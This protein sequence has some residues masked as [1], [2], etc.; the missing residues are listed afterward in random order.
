[1]VLPPPI[2]PDEGAGYPPEQVLDG[3]IVAPSDHWIALFP[4]RR[5]DRRQPPG[6]DGPGRA[7]PPPSRHAEMEA[8]WA[9]ART[10][11][12]EVTR[13]CGNALIKRMF[14]T[15]ADGWRY[16]L[17][18]D[19][20]DARKL[21][22]SPVPTSSIGPALHVLVL[23]TTPTP[24]AHYNSWSFDIEMI[25]RHCGGVFG[26][27]MHLRDFLAAFAW[28]DRS[29]EHAMETT[30]FW[31]WDLEQRLAADRRI[32]EMAR[33]WRQM[34][35][36][37]RAKGFL[38]R[39]KIY[40]AA[41]AFDHW[42]P[43]ARRHAF[44]KYIKEEGRRKRAADLCRWVFRAF[45]MS[46]EA[47]AM[48]RADREQDARLR[49]PVR[50]FLRC[51]PFI[52]TPDQA[53][54][55]GVSAPAKV[56]TIGPPEGLRDIGFVH[57]DPQSA[58]L[59]QFVKMHPLKKPHHG[60]ALLAPQHTQP[61]EIRQKWRAGDGTM[62]VLRMGDGLTDA[63]AAQGLGG[64]GLIKLPSDRDAMLEVEPS[65]VRFEDFLELGVGMTRTVT[66]TNV[67][68]TIRRVRVLPAQSPF[69]TVTCTT[70]RNRGRLAP[71][72]SATIKVVF[73]PQE[74]RSYY[75]CVVIEAECDRTLNVRA[76]L[77]LPLHGTPGPELTSPDIPD[78]GRGALLARNIRPLQRMFRVEQLAL[79]H[80]EQMRQHLAK[81]MSEE[82]EGVPRTEE[83]KEVAAALAELEREIF[84]GGG[85]VPA[86]V[87]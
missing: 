60:G 82:A 13:H 34:V 87:S 49:A 69:F 33:R 47:S 32:K 50:E 85:E 53:F 23:R 9:Y 39:W 62:R 10:K 63:Q 27:Q 24:A 83:L 65:V 36:M 66:M 20:A 19:A 72:M 15:L 52:K 56:Y 1:M 38:R 46:L 57:T 26:G 16:F 45:R 70:T 44:A 71:G 28:D 30:Y 21:C 3:A 7:A 58:S 37:Q 43:W 35:K 11:Q 5:E 67:G 74:K 6:V 48:E 75:D 22:S 25:V 31:L 59:T 54:L 42:G 79:S 80:A 29:F 14:A 61:P 18:D 68:G 78:V 55:A 86:R 81:D 77:Q 2:V 8:E 40:E 4:L 41:K 51:H 12:S 17:K 84:L 64:G 73:T 76:R